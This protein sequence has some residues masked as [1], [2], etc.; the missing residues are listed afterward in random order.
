L[1]KVLA[2][3]N[4]FKLS[5]FLPSQVDLVKYDPNQGPLD[6]TGFDALLIRSV[7]KIR[8]EFINGLPSSLKFIGTGSSGSDHVDK[9]LLKKRDIHFADAKGSNANVV[10]EYVVTSLIALSKKN[11]DILKASIGI[12]GVGAVGTKVYE[13]LD[14]LGHDT[15]LF[16][17]P[18]ETR[19]PN[20]KSSSIDEVLECD[21]LTFH[22]PLENE[23][24]H[25][26]FHWLDSSKLDNQ[27]FLAVIN[28]ARG[29]VIDEQ[30]VL[31]A[32]TDGRIDHLIIDVWEN[33]PDINTE[34]TQHCD[35]ASPH[36]AGSSIQS[37]LNASRM[38]AEQLCSY[39]EL[40]TP[41]IKNS[42]KEILSISTKN[43][44]EVDL[45][46]NIYPLLKYDSEL[47]SILTSNDKN[48]LFA[49]LRTDFPYRNEYPY[50][51]IPDIN[52]DKFPVLKKLGITN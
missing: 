35:I 21:V 40:D 18:R 2:D 37:K 30:V 47:R 38:L 4:L 24:D 29:G 46:T 16:D 32:K 52:L 25:P 42:P 34:F 49:K 41:I 15:V 10:A 33:E 6:L 50:L 14:K 19:D 36:I 22:I 43:S 44:N 48:R 45:I 39:F 23:G 8:K 7:T 51:R 31:E 5:E 9:E 12:I 3:K 27:R 11:K 1:L 17:P 28:A 20:F 13:L 26:T